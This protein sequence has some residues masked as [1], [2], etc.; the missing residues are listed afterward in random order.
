VVGAAVLTPTLEDHILASITRALV[1][2]VVGARER[3]CPLD[4]LLAADE[5]FLA[6]T[7]R[8]VQ[9]VSAIDDHAFDG[10]GAVTARIAAAVE[11]RIRSERSS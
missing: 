8:E 11:A 10:P 1:I 4:E 6:S 3:P 9:P 7:A 5:A 2:D